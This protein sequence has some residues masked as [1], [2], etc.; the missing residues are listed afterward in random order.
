MLPPYDGEIS[1]LPA[2]RLRVSS[3]FQEKRA[4]LSVSICKTSDSEAQ[5]DRVMSAELGLMK[6]D[7]S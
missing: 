6:R 4:F 5:V 2:S 1:L 7:L 3:R